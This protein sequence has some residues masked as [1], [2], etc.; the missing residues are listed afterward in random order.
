MDNEN[1]NNQNIYA[2]FWER[3]TAHFADALIVALA[4]F[5]IQIGSGNNPFIFFSNVS[6]EEMSEFSMNAVGTYAS[7]LVALVYYVGFWVN[8]NGQTPGKKL[9]AIRIIRTNNATLDYGRALIRHVGTYISSTIFL[10]GYFWMIWDKD[11]Q[12][13]HDS[14]AGTYVV[15]TNEEGNKPL[16]KLLAIF[17]LLIGLSFTFATVGFLGRAFMEGVR[18][19][20]QEEGPVRVN[21]ESNSVSNTNVNVNL[22]NGDIE[23]MS[24]EAKVHFDKGEE[25]FKDVAQLASD[26]NASTDQIIQLAN[27]GIRELRTATEIT[28]NDPRPWSSLGNA[29]TWANTEGDLEDSLEAFQKAETLAPNN[30][31]YVSN[32]G[33]ILI[34]LGRYQEAVIQLNKAQRIQPDAPVNYER[35]GNAYL[36]LGLADEAVQSYDTAIE[37]Y[38]ALNGTGRFD[39]N[40]LFNQQKRAQAKQLQ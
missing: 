23:E 37:K 10:L 25:I 2:S 11:K 3:A 40:I 21:T 29:L 14:M 31:E 16:A 33:E 6:V 22:V 13:W 39:N 30:W 12:T 19:G 36:A 24:P 20:M 8:S 28:P 9:M 27:E 26:P 34:R 5:A 1:A 4:T 17:G 35:L 15:R 32:V 7:Y 18:E 38:Q